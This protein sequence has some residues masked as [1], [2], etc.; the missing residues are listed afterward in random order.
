[1]KK[2]P[3]KENQP[4]R[5]KTVELTEQEMIDHLAECVL[6]VL[7]KDVQKAHDP[8]DIYAC[9]LKV[10][11]HRKGKVFRERMVKGHEVLLEALQLTSH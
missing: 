8:F 9:Q 11:F 4:K 1:M 2:K 7:K 5:V 10:R 3:E 6:Y